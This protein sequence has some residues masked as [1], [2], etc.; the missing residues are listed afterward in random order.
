MLLSFLTGWTFT[1]VICIWPLNFYPPWQHSRTL[2]FFF[3][4][5][6]SAPFQKLGHR[7]SFSL[8]VP[9]FPVVHILVSFHNYYIFHLLYH[10]DLHSPPRQCHF[11]L[12]LPTLSP[13]FMSPASDNPSADWL[14]FVD[15][16]TG[17]NNTGKHWT[18]THPLLQMV[19]LSNWTSFMGC[20]YRSSSCFKIGVSFPRI[21]TTTFTILEKQIK[22]DSFIR[23]Y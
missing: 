12:S 7:S 22:N 8:F 19:A 17:C 4:R 11:F 23:F 14:V 20:L 5:I 10:S 13:P 21:F 6:L 3:L 18:N 16:Y 15:F 9:C 1:D 2:F